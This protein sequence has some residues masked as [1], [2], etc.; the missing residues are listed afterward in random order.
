MHYDNN[1]LGEDN[2]YQ[3]AKAGNCQS[4]IIAS[5]LVIQRKRVHFR[6]VNASLSCESLGVHDL[7]LCDLREEFVESIDIARG[8]GVE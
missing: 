4:R 5:I 8:L 6:N 7:E 3:K 1:G 2:Q